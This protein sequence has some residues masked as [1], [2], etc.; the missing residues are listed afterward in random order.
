MAYLAL[1]DPRLHSH[2]RPSPR[3]GLPQEPSITYSSLALGAIL[4]AVLD[5]AHFI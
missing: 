2:V 4:L 1:I 5:D 3:A